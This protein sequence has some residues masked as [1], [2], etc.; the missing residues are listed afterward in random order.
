MNSLHNNTCGK[1][2]HLTKNVDD[3]SRKIIRVLSLL[4]TV[5]FI[6]L[7]A[8][9]STLDTTSPGNSQTDRQTDGRTD[10]WMDGYATA[11]AALDETMLIDVNLVQKR[12]T[13]LKYYPQQVQ[14][15]RRDET[16]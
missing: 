14:D 10:G 4:V 2:N 13:K 9:L 11:I 8:V 1:S 7:N 5:N 12:I 15:R 6:P 3:T 16:S